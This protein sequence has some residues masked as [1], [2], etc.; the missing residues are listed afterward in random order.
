VSH[1]D[2]EMNVSS[3]DMVRGHRERLHAL[4][5][6][7]KRLTRVGTLGEAID[8]MERLHQARMTWRASVDEQE[9]LRADLRSALAKSYRKMAPEDF[10]LIYSRAAEWLDFHTARAPQPSA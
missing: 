4:T 5:A 10:W 7:G 8:L 6:A 3:A 9:L 1:A 2:Y